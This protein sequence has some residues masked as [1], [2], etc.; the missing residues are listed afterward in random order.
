MESPLSIHS[1]SI[2]LGKWEV[3]RDRKSRMLTMQ[4]LSGREE[5]KWTGGYLWVLLIQSSGFRS[6]SSVC[7]PMFCARKQSRR[8]PCVS[9]P[10]SDLFPRNHWLIVLHNSPGYESN[11]LHQDPVNV[12]RNTPHT[13]LGA[14]VHQDGSQQTGPE[15]SSEV[16]GIRSLEPLKL[17]IMCDSSVVLPFFTFAPEQ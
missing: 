2:S 13:S 8:W 11:I 4:Q 3:I 9:F 5:S 15:L 6:E 16:T 12:A 1:L 17:L 14:W 7:S 10:E